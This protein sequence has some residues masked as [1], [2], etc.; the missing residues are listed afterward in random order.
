MW[1]KQVSRSR[2]KAR[3]DPEVFEVYLGKKRVE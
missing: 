3:H 1:L 2:K